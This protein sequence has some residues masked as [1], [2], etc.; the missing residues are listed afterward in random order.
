[1]RTSM[2]TKPLEVARSGTGVGRVYNHNQTS[3]PR[4]PK[5]EGIPS[6]ES[7]VKKREQAAGCTILRSITHVRTLSTCGSSSSSARASAP[8]ARCCCQGLIASAL[9][10]RAALW[11]SQQQPHPGC[12]HCDCRQLLHFSSEEL[13]LHLIATLC[14]RSKMVTTNRAATSP[15]GTRSLGTRSVSRHSSRR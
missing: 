8:G 1:M 4:L 3:Q 5:G 6:K 11:R 14:V 9:V 13:V 15:G 12:L 10:A 7:R 2:A